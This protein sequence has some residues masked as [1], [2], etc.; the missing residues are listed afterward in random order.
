M[1]AYDPKRTS[2][3]GIKE[4]ICLGLS[5]VVNREGRHAATRREQTATQGAAHDQ[6]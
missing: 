6:A 2:R 1:S 5:I 3:H 4:G